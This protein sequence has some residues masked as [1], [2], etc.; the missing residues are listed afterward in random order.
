MTPRD[1]SRLRDHDV[2]LVVDVDGTL[3]TGDLLVEGVARLI[4]TSPW[5]AFLLPWWLLR[6]RAA[7]K[8]RVAQAVP[9]SPAA[10]PLNAEVVAEIEAAKRQNRPVWLASGADEFAVARLTEFIDGAGCLASDGSRNLVGK[11]KAEALVARF[12]SSGF[13]YIGNHRHDLPVWRESRLAI[14]VGV[15]TGLVRELRATGRNPKLLGGAT[16]DWRDWLY[17]LRPHQWTKNTLV[18]VPLLAAHE[19]DGQAW[20]FTLGV[21]AALC[22][23]ASG[24]YVFNDLLDLPDDRQHPGKRQRPIAAGKVSPLPI[25]WLGMALVVG[26]VLA[27]FSLASA[28]GYLL[29]CYVVG[30]LGYSLWLKRRLFVDVVALALLYVIRIGMGATESA[31][32]SPWLLAFSLFVFLALAVVKRQTELVSAAS[33]LPESRRPYVGEDLGVMAALGAASAFAAAV[34]LALY[35]QSPDVAVRYSRPELLGLACPVLIY[36]LGRL[37]LLANRGFVDHDPIVFALRDRTSWLVA[38]TMGGAVV[39]AI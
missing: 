20:L 29:L 27:G 34:V 15:S 7:L 19:V 8:R 1:E 11:A 33:V 21:G 3:V 26:G 13:D 4:A 30:T 10:L 35:I 17:A 22:C 32:I 28:G 12:G 6:G 31:V 38:L 16:G 36:W 9:L 18:F 2:P 37:L 39:A 23:C 14:G 5:K 25:A 24:T